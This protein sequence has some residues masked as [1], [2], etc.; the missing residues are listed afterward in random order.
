MYHVDWGTA[1][2]GNNHLQTSLA[3]VAV[4]NLRKDPVV[5]ATV[6]AAYHFQLFLLRLSLKF[7]FKSLLRRG[8]VQNSFLLYIHQ[9]HEQNQNDYMEMREQTK[10]QPYKLHI[11]SNYTN[12]VWLN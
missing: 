3:A 10:Q 11:K 1:T 7:N 9:I 5:K 4:P 6:V 2:P 12:I 8:G